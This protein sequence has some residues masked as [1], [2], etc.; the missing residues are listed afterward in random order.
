MK[1]ILM[2]G[3]GAS[4]LLSTASFISNLPDS[5]K[6]NSAVAQTST[7]QQALKL[8]LAA[9]KQV[10]VKDEQSK[11]KITWQ[12]LN[13]KAIVKPRDIL[14]Y[15]LTGENISDRPLKNINFNQPIAKGMVY[16]LKSANFTGNAKISYSIDGGRSFVEN[17]TI[18]VTLPNGNIQT[19]SAPASAYTHLRFYS[20]VIA[21]KTTLKFT[22]QTQ[23]R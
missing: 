13:N 1:Q 20:P 2:T 5:W 14:R 11:Q 22:Y 4:L 10:L 9:E 16:V 3:I 17:P 7:K 12:A 18:K 21:A 8:V 15:T 19:Q 23:V 6:T